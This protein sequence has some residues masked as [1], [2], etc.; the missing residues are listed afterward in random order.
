MI[1]LCSVM[2]DKI[3]NYRKIL[4]QSILERTK[5]VSEVIFAN[6]SKEPSYYDKWMERGIIFREFGSQENYPWADGGNQHALGLHYA[7]DRASQDYLYFCDPD[8]FFYT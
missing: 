4:I 7:L 5:L 8:I 2:L 3:Q 1:T 6:N